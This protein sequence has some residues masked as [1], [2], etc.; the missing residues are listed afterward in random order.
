[1]EQ[2]IN[3]VRIDQHE[4]IFKGENIDIGKAFIKEIFPIIS[5][6]WY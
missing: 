3:F 1:M 5:I 4:N 6:Y 2:S